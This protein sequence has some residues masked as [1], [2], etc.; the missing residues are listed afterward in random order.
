MNDLQNENNIYIETTNNC[1]C[2]K[3]VFNFL[4]LENEFKVYHRNSLNLEESNVVLKLFES[5][6]E[7]EEVFINSN[8]VSLSFA[9]YW[10]SDNNYIEA[11]KKL[12]YDFIY[13]HKNQFFNREFT[14]E[15]EKIQKFLDEY[16]NPAVEMEGGR[17]QLYNYSLKNKT[18]ILQAIGSCRNN[19]SSEIDL[20]QIKR[21]YEN[22]HNTVLKTIT[23]ININN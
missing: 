17:Y 18:L 2:Y 14:I 11:I 21:I 23:T 16:I 1:N 4:F 3:F 10:S 6:P 7:I 8:Y 9:N 12:L 22:V 20:F 19:I 13:I 5:Y 15:T